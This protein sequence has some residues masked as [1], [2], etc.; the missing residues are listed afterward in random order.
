MNKRNLIIAASILVFLL[1]G[2]ALIK[3]KHNSNNNL[4]QTVLG[5]TL[6]ISK[7]YLNLRLLTDNT[8]T[9][10]S[11]Y[12]D[13]RSWNKQMAAL[14]NMWQE[15]DKS[16]GAL[17]SLAGGYAGEKVSWNLLNPAQAVTTEEINNVFDNAPAGKKIRTLAKFLG[18]DAKR[19]YK[20][21]E[22]TQN[23]VK[24]DAW[25]EA[26]DEFQKLETT[27]VVIK[28]GC[29]VAGFVGG[30]I[31]T[32]GTSAI[33][34]GSTLSQVAVVVTGADLVL[35][36]SE[37]AA[38]I[39][40]GNNNDA[41]A[42]IGDIRKFTEP[43]AA[44]LAITDLPNNIA[45]NFDKF[46]AFMFGLDNF[47][48]T[49]QEGKVIGIALPVYDGKEIKIN[50]DGAVMDRSELEEWLQSQGY[51]GYEDYLA[52]LF[53]PGAE[54]A[55]EASAPEEAAPADAAAAEASAPEETAGEAETKETAA[56]DGNY[57]ITPD[58]VYGQDGKVSITLESPLDPVFQRG[59]ARMWEIKV[60]N[61]DEE[62]A[63]RSYTC[64]WSFYLGGEL[65]REQADT[66]RFTSTFIDKA[67]DLTAEL[68]FKILQGRSVFDENGEYIDYVKDTV[69]TL[70]LTQEYSVEAPVDTYVHP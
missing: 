28:D 33:A 10:A 57:Q 52:G 34:A 49:A 51:D 29:K 23:E 45:T 7:Q 5:D 59:Q 4:E 20:M 70:T 68:K 32:G 53:G 12:T 36:V 22:Q 58:T 35:E 19:A 11:E 64:D 27:A 50:I 63:G 42:L 8:L 14:L 40:L 39:S 6:D 65:Y 18:V 47:R 43:A 66:C 56:N 41:A 21:L 15:L 44:I 46:N 62:T 54:T 13:Y 17:E 38:N 3:N 26:G 24:A 55:A 25:N 60:N 2:F 31:I 69:D 30:V 48:S 1:L 37:D 61:W 16:A 9:K 67:G